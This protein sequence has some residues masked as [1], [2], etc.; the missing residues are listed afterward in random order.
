M[1]V[2]VQ[3][4][5][6]VRLC[7]PM[8]RSTPALPVHHQLPESTQTHVRRVGDAI[9]P[10]HPVVPFSS[11]LQSF[12]ASGSFPMSQFFASGGQSIGV[13]ASTS[14]LPTNVTSSSP[15]S[16]VGP[17]L[18]KRAVGDNP[19]NSTGKFSR[20]WWSPR[21]QSTSEKVLAFS[22]SC[23]TPATEDLSQRSDQPSLLSLRAS[24]VG[25]ALRSLCLRLC[26]PSPTHPAW[27]AA[28]LSSHQPSPTSSLCPRSSNSSDTMPD[29]SGP[30]STTQ[31][32][33]GSSRG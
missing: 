27:K 31:P 23:K 3:S 8:D 11:R 28:S 13:S 16:P 6:R 9:Q 24:Q 10:S 1:G 25:S 15:F 29:A 12:P 19:Y 22:C 30:S 21:P 33:R 4:L 5:H 18:A 20:C 2:S 14:V 26:D 17:S 32:T 7:N